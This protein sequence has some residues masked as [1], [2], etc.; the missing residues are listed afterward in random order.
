MKG[1]AFDVRA[2]MEEKES[3]SNVDADMVLQ[4]SSVVLTALFSIMAVSNEKRRNRH[5]RF[6]D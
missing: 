6:V 5:H 3:S 1:E 4:F 2:R